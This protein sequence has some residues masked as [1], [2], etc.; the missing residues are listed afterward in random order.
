MVALANGLNEDGE[1]AEMEE[2]SEDTRPAAGLELPYSQRTLEQRELT[3]RHLALGLL[4]L[5]GAAAL[6]PEL[7]FIFNRWTRLDA[8]ELEDLSIFFTPLV[9][10]ASAAFGFFFGSERLDSE[11]SRDR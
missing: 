5:V 6:L 7:A 10:L 9:T 8:K 1:P 3:R 11:R 2:L 4:V